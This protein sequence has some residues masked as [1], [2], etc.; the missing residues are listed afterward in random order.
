MESS[1]WQWGRHH[2][3]PTR[4]TLFGFPEWPHDGGLRSTLVTAIARRG[5]RPGGPLTDTPRIGLFLADDN[6]IVREGV[7]VLLEMEDDFEAVRS[8]SSSTYLMG[9]WVLGFGATF[10][11]N[12]S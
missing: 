7:R 10:P 11:T 2:R 1:E 5:P 4:C 6:L 12:L 9:F 3:I 8:S